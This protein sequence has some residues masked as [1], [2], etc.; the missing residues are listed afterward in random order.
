MALQ[1]QVN[2]KMKITWVFLVM[3]LCCWLKSGW[4]LKLL[5]GAVLSRIYV[6]GKLSSEI[7]LDIKE[8]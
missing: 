7:R 2:V 3:R 8:L 1:P 4:A 5:D 6:N